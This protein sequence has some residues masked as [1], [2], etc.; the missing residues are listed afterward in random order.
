ME[1]ALFNLFDYQRFDRNELLDMLINCADAPLKKRHKLTRSIS[2]VA[3]TNVSDEIMGLAFA[4]GTP[5]IEPKKKCE[6]CK[7]RE[8]TQCSSSPHR[9][10]L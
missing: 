5:D 8:N 6:L 7:W 1:E 3:N 10:E 2:S 9:I 4:A